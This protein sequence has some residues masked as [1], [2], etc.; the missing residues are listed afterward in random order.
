MAY[1]SWPDTIAGLKDMIG[2]SDTAQGRQCTTSAQG[3]LKVI[4]KIR[5]LDGIEKLIPATSQCMIILTTAARTSRFDIGHDDFS[6][7][8][9][10]T[11]DG[12]SAPAYLRNVD[13]GHLLSELQT[14]IAAVT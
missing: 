8:I 14:F 13:E 6:Y 2:R 5:A 9:A 7:L 10:S 3:V 12:I 4:P 11:T 1:G